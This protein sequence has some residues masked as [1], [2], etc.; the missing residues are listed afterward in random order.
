MFVAGDEMISFEQALKIVDETLGGVKPEGEVVPAPEA[1][2]R[3]LLED[4]LSRLD[5]PPFDK[6]AMDGFAVLEGDERGEYRLIETVAAGEIAG[7]RLEPGT[8]IQVMTGAPVPEGTG[9]VIMVEHTEREGD[10]VRVTRPDS[11]INIARRAE[12]VRAGDRVLPAGTRLSAADIANLISCGVV[13]VKVAK[14]VRIAVIC[15]GDEIVDSPALIKPGRIMNSNGPMLAALAEENGLELTGVEKVPDDLEKTRAA[16]SRAAEEADI[17][18]L[19]GGVSMGEFDY[20]IE[21]LAA[22]GFK[23]HFSRV[24]MKPGKPMTFATRDRKVVFGLPGNPVSVYLTFHLFVMRAVSLVSGA[25]PGLRELTLTLTDDY[26]RKRAERTGF[27]PCRLGKKGEVK[28]VEYHGS[29][30]LA[31]LSEADGFMVIPKGIMEMEKG[32]TVRFLPLM[33]RNG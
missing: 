12:D 27:V 10:I 28:P 22:V 32:G 31:A 30:H 3:F 4:E 33:K 8:T 18:V 20:V 19:S 15:T 13:E 5:L 24:A 26:K 23:V 21:A 11:R 2:G 1:L 9:K 14:R 17:V 16:M 25:E 29:A 7:K 6:S